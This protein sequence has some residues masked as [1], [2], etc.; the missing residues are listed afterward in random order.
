MRGFLSES[1]LVVAKS[2]QRND[3]FV[4]GVDL[5]DGLRGRPELSGSR[6]EALELTIHA[7]PG[8]TRQ[9]ALSVSRSEARTS[10][11]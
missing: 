2:G 4:L 1:L 6:Q 10:E 8:A 11:T 3:E 9:T 7:P 5:E